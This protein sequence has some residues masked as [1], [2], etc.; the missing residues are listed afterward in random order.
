MKNYSFTK[1]IEPQLTM[2]LKRNGQWIKVQVSEVI[3]GAVNGVPYCHNRVVLPS[4]EAIEINNS[5]LLPL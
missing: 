1:P 2:S 3:H 4:G 5:E